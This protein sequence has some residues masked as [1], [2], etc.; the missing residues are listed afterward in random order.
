MLNPEERESIQEDQYHDV[1]NDFHQIS[2]EIQSLYHNY[3]KR[4]KSASEELSKQKSKHHLYEMEISENHNT[5]EVLTAQI[6]HLLH[7]RVTSRQMITQFR[8]ELNNDNKEHHGIEGILDNESKTVP[9]ECFPEEPV[10]YDPGDF[11]S[12]NILPTSIPDI[13]IIYESTL[14]EKKKLLEQMT[15]RLLTLIIQSHEHL[16]ISNSEL[17]LT[18]YIK[19]INNELELIRLYKKY[20]VKKE[21]WYMKV[22]KFLWGK[23]EE[24]N[25][26]EVL[27]KLE[28]IERHLTDYA[29]KFKEV[30]EMLKLG[31]EQDE[32]TRSY[33]GKMNSLHTELKKIEGYYEEEIETLKTQLDEYKQRESELESKL[34]ILDEKYKDKSKT[35]SVR[36]SQLEEE[37]KKLRSEIQAQSNKKNDL[38]KKIK[39]PSTPSKPKVAQNNPEFDQFGSGSIP[40]AAESKKT[41]FNPNNYLR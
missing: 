2:D 18:P 7:D 12:V 6:E 26:P 27:K 5:I 10:E 40:F 41:M 19:A 37:L 38:Y 9:E 14:D 22:W 33:L 15:K 29:D 39:H 36:E 24:D 35:P 16:A 31:S 1:L 17:D 8:T 3:S 23:Q 34:S 30:N 28:E 13:R 21:R 20:S 32:T 25:N 4:I 11:P